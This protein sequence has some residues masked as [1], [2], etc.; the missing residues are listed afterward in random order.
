MIIA[1]LGFLS[2][3]MGL[4]ATQIKVGADYPIMASA[5][6]AAGAIYIGYRRDTSGKMAVYSR[7]LFGIYWV[8]R[9]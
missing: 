6:I 9:Q 5:I 7:F 8:G 2:L 3:L 1:C 4:M